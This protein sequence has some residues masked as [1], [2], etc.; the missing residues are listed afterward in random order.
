MYYHRVAEDLVKQYLKLF[1]VIGIM[2]PRQSGKSTML[3]RLLG[4]EYTYVTFDDF[5]QK[6]L[7]FN[8]PRKFISR[9]NRKVIFDEA[10]YVPE[11]FPMIKQVVDN[12]RFNYG[13]FI[14]TGSGQFLMGK[15]ISESLAGRIGLIP[16]MPL[17]LSEIPVGRQNYFVYSGGYPE[18]VVRRWEGKQA[19]YNAYLETYI[20]KDLRQMTNIS[21]LHSFTTFLRFLAA[22]ATQTLNLSVISREIG[23]SVA[24]LKRWTSVLESSYIIFLLQPYFRNLGKRLIKSPKIYFVDTGLLSFLTGIQTGQDWEKGIMYG[25]IFENCIV[26]EL[27]KRTYHTGSAS[28]MFF[29]RTNHGDEIDVILETGGKPDLIEIKASETYRPSFHRT[30]NK[31]D[32]EAGSKLVIYQGKTFNVI[33]NILAVNY[34]DYLIK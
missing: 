27:L 18:L 20:Q 25:Q 22:N 31:F 21:D 13:N 5:E 34:V 10:Q 30:I 15:N 6:E 29:Y 1:P 19:W 12:D 14:L 8:D 2:G 26:S 16:L 9:Y 17:Q 3:R 32:F 7:F 23:I 28:R 33:D 4:K 24:T 11:L